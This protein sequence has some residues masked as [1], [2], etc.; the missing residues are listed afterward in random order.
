MRLFIAV[1][2]SGGALDWLCEKVAL[3]RENSFKGSFS[4]RDNLHLTLIFLGEVAFDRVD[5]IK[6]AMDEVEA[7][8]FELKMAGLGRF[9]RN[10]GDIVWAGVEMSGELLSIYEQLAENLIKRGFRVE[11]GKFTPHITLGG[12]VALKNGLKG[13]PDDSGFVE[14]ADKISLMLSE[15]TDGGMRYTGIYEKGLR[16]DKN[17]S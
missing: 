7:D 6:S 17:A 14:R 8:C 5:L 2:F 16:R 4:K 11:K 3:L 9:K 13:I 12:R 10:D 1:N 15:R